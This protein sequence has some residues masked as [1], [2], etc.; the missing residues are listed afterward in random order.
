MKSLLAIPSGPPS[1]VVPGPPPRPLGVVHPPSGVSSPSGVPS[2]PPRPS[3]LPPSG[4]PSPPPRPAGLPPPPRPLGLPVPPPSGLPSPPPSTPLPKPPSSGLL[5]PSSV[6]NNANTGFNLAMLE[7]A[8]ATTQQNED[9][10]NDGWSD[11]DTNVPVASEKITVIPRRQSV[12]AP[13]AVTL[14]PPIKKSFIATGLVTDEIQASLHITPNTM[15]I[16]QEQK[17]HTSPEQIDELKKEEPKIVV[18]EDEKIVKEANNVLEKLVE[19]QQ[20][21]PKDFI[22]NTNDIDEDNE[23]KHSSTSQSVRDARKIRD[24][25]AVIFDLK[26]K[27]EKA[28]SRLNQQSFILGSKARE[29]ELEKELDTSYE[30]INALKTENGS[31]QDSVKAL[32]IRLTLAETKNNEALAI[33]IIPKVPEKDIKSM[34]R[35][36]EMEKQ[37]LKMKDEKDKVVRLII[38]LIGKDRMSQFL[39]THSNE[40]DILSA[41]VEN[42]SNGTSLENSKNIN[43]SNNNSPRKRM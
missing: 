30:R 10:D 5:V 40:D 20:H 13:P 7:K 33:P 31:L 6:E 8:K 12:N 2:P 18:K 1:G 28:E 11:D 41:L 27:L 9:D 3:G 43:K 36:K 21:Q 19:K 23:C 24:L 42:F 35:M 4:L 15:P 32:Q 14:P 29:A 26:R 37:L 25:E 22:D 34:E 17:K 38:L 16:V 39:K